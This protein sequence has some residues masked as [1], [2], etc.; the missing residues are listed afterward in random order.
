M[1]IALCGVKGS[2][3]DTVAS[4]IATVYSEQRA[5]KRVAFADPIKRV[6]QDIF[7]LNP[8]VID[9]YDQFKRTQ[10]S[11][12]LPGYLSHGVPG[13]NVVREIGM[14]MRGYNEQQFV[15]YVANTMDLDPNAI[16]VITDLRFENELEFVR[17]R[18]A[19]VVKVQRQGAASD[20]HCTEMCF[21]DEQ[22]DVVFNNDVPKTL[23]DAKVKT[24][25]DNFIKVK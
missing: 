5:V 11:Y 3:K 12:T 16:W 24:V 13:R 17:R 23:L 1:I 6:V 18:G 4:S 22:C 21:A 2:G 9:Q 15:D 25:F 8:D 20:G 7:D 14:L 19:L 10:V